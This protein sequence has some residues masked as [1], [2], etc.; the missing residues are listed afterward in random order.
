MLLGLMFVGAALRLWRLDESYWL[1]EALT[2]KYVAMSPGE[3]MLG[4]WPPLYRLG[5]HAWLNLVGAAESLVRLPSVLFGVLAIPLLYAVGARLLTPRVGLLAATL[6]TVSSF[7]LHY[8]QEARYYALLQ[9]LVLAS[10]YAYVRVR[11]RGE[12]GWI[13]VHAL[14]SIAAVEAHFFGILSLAAQGLHILVCGPPLRMAW[15][16]L[17]GL[18][19]AAVLV[20]VRLLLFRRTIAGSALDPTEWLPVPSAWAPLLVLRDFLGWP[21]TP[22]GLGATVSVILLALLAGWRGRSEVP[23]VQARLFLWFGVALVVLV[24]VVFSWVARPMYFPRYVIAA[25]PLVY[26]ISADGLIRLPWWWLRWGLIAVCLGLSVQGTWGYFATPQKPDWRA[27]GAY[28][29]ARTRPGDVVWIAP[30]SH[31]DG[32]DWYYDGPA[33]LCPWFHPDSPNGATISAECRGG[34]QRLW[35]VAMDGVRQREPGILRDAHRLSQMG[36]RATFAPYLHG[37]NVRLYEPPARR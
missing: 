34:W 13:V 22:I 31:T 1:D 6:L 17:V 3:I 16:W 20:G 21:Y 12:L 2:M 23:Q 18:G 27:T 19:V 4:P 11:Q 10:T 33:K 37:L 36:W 26:L 9:L 25:A 28:L 14:T 15:R 7:Q 24:P 30:G 5:M 8:S 32:L 35:V 29:Q